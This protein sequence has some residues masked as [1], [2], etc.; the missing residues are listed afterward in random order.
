[1]NYL[2]T[3]Y[4]T[5]SFQTIFLQNPSKPASSSKPHTLNKFRIVLIEAV[6]EITQHQMENVF[7]GL[8]NQNEQ[9]ITKDGGCAEVYI[10]E[11]D[12]VKNSSK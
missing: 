1:M 5:W 6:H 3:F 10:F 11:S 12:S 8:E 7:N 4:H 9:C 2:A